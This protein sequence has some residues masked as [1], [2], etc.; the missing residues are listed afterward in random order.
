MAELDVLTSILSSG[1]LGQDAKEVASNI[2]SLLAMN[3]YEIRRKSDPLNSVDDAMPVQLQGA[4]ELHMGF[5]AMIA[6]GFTR[7]EAFEMIKIILRGKVQA[8]RGG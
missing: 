2:I 6:S 7:E 5:D 8:Y 1:P 4:I 3:D